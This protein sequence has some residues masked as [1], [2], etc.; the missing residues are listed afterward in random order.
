MQSQIDE[1][2]S[3]DL[4]SESNVRNIAEIDQHVTQEEPDY[5][6]QTPTPLASQHVVREGSFDC[7]D[8]AE[9][10]KNFSE[11][12]HDK[13]LPAAQY[14]LEQRSRPSKDTYVETADDSESEQ[15]SPTDHGN[16]LHDQDA[17]PNDQPSEQTATLLTQN[18]SDILQYPSRKRKHNL[19]RGRDSKRSYI[20]A[21]DATEIELG[22]KSLQ[23]SR[24][25]E[26]LL[27][28]DQDGRHDQQPEISEARKDGRLSITAATL[29]TPPQTVVRSRR[30]SS[31]PPGVDLSSG[32]S[33]KF[34]QLSAALRAKL[35]RIADTAILATVWD[36]LNYKRTPL[37]SV[38]DCVESSEQD[39]NPGIISASDQRLKKLKNRIVK[40]EKKKKFINHK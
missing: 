24:S 31:V 37:S 12:H 38:D 28:T 3:L 5:D 15:S 35:G 40:N 17:R 2:A 27:E 34:A 11:R 20:E 19:E 4:E 21:T 26:L 25:L 32:G 6:D 8:P 30:L 13:N 22:S 10:Y 9:Q 7:N 36:Y 18:E 16:D 23:F 33:D 39:S 1:I 14:E 29:P